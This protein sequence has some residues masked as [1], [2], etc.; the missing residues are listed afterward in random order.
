MASSLGPQFSAP[1]GVAV[2]GI[3]DF[4][5]IP[6]IPKLGKLAPQKSG[7]HGT[8]IDIPVGG[9]IL[10][11]S[12]TSSQK[13]Q[14]GLDDQTYFTPS[15]YEAWGYATGSQRHIG[16][17]PRVYKTQ[18]RGIQ[19]VDENHEKQ[20][21]VVGPDAGTRYTED[22]A[23]RTVKSQ[24]VTDVEWTPPPMRDT[25]NGWVQGTLPEVNWNDW[26][27]PNWVESTGDGERYDDMGVHESASAYK[28]RDSSPSPMKEN[29]DFPSHKFNPDQFVLPGLEDWSPKA[30]EE[31]KS[32][33]PLL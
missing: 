13:S 19:R 18:P 1:P 28:L 17:R 11:P 20:R 31:P 23:P 14:A 24:I 21:I 29:A 6:P 10:P 12:M 5:E 22:T 26:G 3:P 7:W 32:D 8:K 15:N 16:Q 9:R 4:P 27:Y 2:G 25:K 33:Q 30:P